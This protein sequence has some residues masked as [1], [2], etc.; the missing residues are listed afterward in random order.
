[1]KFGSIQ[2]TDGSFYGTTIL[3]GA[4]DG[5]AALIA[6]FLA[7]ALARSFDPQLQN[8][9]GLRHAKLLPRAP[10]SGWAARRWSRRPGP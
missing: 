7:I 5:C 1:M 2:A 9:I 3:R 8:R 6:R 10:A 4:A